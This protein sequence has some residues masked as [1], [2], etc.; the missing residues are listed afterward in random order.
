MLVSAITLFVGS[1]FMMLITNVIMA[2]T[3]VAAIFIGFML[4]RV[5]TAHSQK[6]FARQQRHLGELNGHIEEMYSGHTVVKAYNDEE[7]AK[8]NF[9]ELNG[10]LRDSAFRAQCLAGLICRDSSSFTLEE[11][12]IPHLSPFSCYPSPYPGAPA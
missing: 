6:Y 3:A 9:D 7:N 1:L 2:L 11:N 8:K 5:I 10:T 4:M 12:D